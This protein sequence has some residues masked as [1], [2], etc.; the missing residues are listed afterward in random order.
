MKR[1]SIIIPVY[2]EVNTIAEVIKKVSAVELKDIE[3]EIIIVQ[4]KHLLAHQV[5]TLA[6]VLH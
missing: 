1:L 3:K 2:N 6:V 4:S 5:Q